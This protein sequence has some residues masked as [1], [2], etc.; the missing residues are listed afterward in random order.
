MP[1]WCQGDRAY[2]MSHYL[3]SGVMRIGPQEEQWQRSSRSRRGRCSRSTFGRWG[4]DFIVKPSTVLYWYQP[5][6]AE[7]PHLTQDYNNKSKVI[8]LNKDRKRYLRY[9]KWLQKKEVSTHKSSSQ[10]KGKESFSLAQQ[11]IDSHQL[12]AITVWD[13][14]LS[15]VPY[16]HASCSQPW[17]SLLFTGSV[18]HVTH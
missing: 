13:P 7:V 4:R 6:E 1:G 8:I 18:A 15:S 3:C 17:G 16:S 11:F 5:S 14:L 2:Q 9:F 12:P 10:V